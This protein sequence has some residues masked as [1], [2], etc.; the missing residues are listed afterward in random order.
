MSNAAAIHS[1]AILAI[2]ADSNSC[3]NL[4]N[5]NFEISNLPMSILQ[6]IKFTIVFSERECLLKTL[7]NAFT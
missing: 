6:Y 5:F 4:A 2:Q 1:Y 7:N 3:R